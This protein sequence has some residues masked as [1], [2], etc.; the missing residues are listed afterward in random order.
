MQAGGLVILFAFSS[1][2]YVFICGDRGS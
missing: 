1:E 2:A